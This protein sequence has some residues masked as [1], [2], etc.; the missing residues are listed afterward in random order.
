LLPVYGNYGGDEPGLIEDNAVYD[1]VLARTLR[2]ADAT[3]QAA[4]ER[5]YTKGDA[6]PPL[7]PMAPPAARR[8]TRVMDGVEAAFYFAMAVSAVTVV[9]ALWALLGWR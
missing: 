1:P 8:K 3:R 9:A 5:H 2:A 7:R 6:A 4:V